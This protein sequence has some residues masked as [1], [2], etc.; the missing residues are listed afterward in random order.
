MTAQ[1]EKRVALDEVRPWTADELRRAM[2][3]AHSNAPAAVPA[4]PDLKKAAAAA[5]VSV[6]TVQRWLS[7]DSRPRPDNA[8]ALRASL[9]PS[10]DILRR[11]QMDRQHQVT[12]AASLAHDATLKRPRPAT[13]QARTLGWHT[14]HVLWLL[15]HE[16]LGICRLM[17][18]MAHPVK[19]TA[20]PAGWTL[21]DRATY[22]DRP[23]ALV[24]K[25]D[26]L[27]RLGPWRVAVSAS[28]V[29]DGRHEC[30]LDTAPRHLALKPAS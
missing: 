16:Q 22:G 15:H 3:L 27:D 19:P 21:R 7:G 9:A 30:W 11:Q 5:G 29:D 14:P 10:A 25:Y 1:L 12:L 20:I 4:G 18:S 24:A 13:R 2:A 23:S 28:L 26:A 6:R 17:V 8:R